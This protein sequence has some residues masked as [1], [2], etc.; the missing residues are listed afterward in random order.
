MT[1][2]EQQSSATTIIRNSLVD[3]AELARC[4]FTGTLC[5]ATCISGPSPQLSKYCLIAGVL[6]IGK[7]NHVDMVRMDAYLAPSWQKCRLFGNNLRF[8][9]SERLALMLGYI[10][11]GQRLTSPTP[12]KGRSS[13]KQV[14]SAAVRSFLVLSRIIEWNSCCTL[15]SSSESGLSTSMSGMLLFLSKLEMPPST[16]AH[17]AKCDPQKGVPMKA[18]PIVCS[19]TCFKWSSALFLDARRS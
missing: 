11:D 10:E 14:I 16:P 1:L 7:S 13:K 19:S 3:A 8:I 18:I 5:R 17:A 4:T 9:L 6:V 15:A 12:G 2:C